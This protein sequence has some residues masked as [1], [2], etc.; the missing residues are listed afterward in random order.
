MNVFESIVVYCYWSLCFYLMFLFLKGG[1]MLRKLLH[2]YD[3]IIDYV[4]CPSL[5]EVIIII[6]I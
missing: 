4:I 1:V 5:I 2:K 3:F 6:L